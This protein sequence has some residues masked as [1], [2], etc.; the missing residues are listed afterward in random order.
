[1]SSAWRVVCLPLC[2]L[3]LTS[4]VSIFAW[5][6]ALLIKLDFPTPEGPAKTDILFC[7]TCFKSS[8]PISFSALKHNTVYPAERYNSAIF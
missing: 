5:G 8:I 3:E 2:I 6:N 4:P 7:S 1:M